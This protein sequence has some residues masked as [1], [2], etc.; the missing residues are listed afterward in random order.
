[1]FEGKDERLHRRCRRHVFLARFCGM[2]WGRVDKARANRVHP[3]ATIL[4]S[5]VQVRA[6]ER[7]AA[8]VAL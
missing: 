8:L 2:P 4:K 3:N 5:V 7:T 6:N 1:M